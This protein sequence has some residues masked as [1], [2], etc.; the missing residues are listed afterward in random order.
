VSRVLITFYW[1]NLKLMD[2]ETIEFIKDWLKLGSVNIF[3]RPFSGKDTQGKMLAKELDAM[4]IGGGEILRKKYDSKKI[5]ESLNAGKLAPTKNY[6]TIVLPYLNDPGFSNKPLVL[7]SVGRWKGE[8]N[9]VIKASEES[10]H[11]LKAVILIDVPENV[12]WER[13]EAHKKIM[14]RGLRGDDTKSALT[15]RLQEYKQKTVPVINHYKGLEML[16]TI[17]GNRQPKVIFLDIIN[18]LINFIDESDKQYN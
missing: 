14:D 12:V 1:Y 11:P 18:Q 10:G 13:W 17:N 4:L 8:E 15:T 6:K 5:Q 16:L 2:A 3:G 7:N 9:D